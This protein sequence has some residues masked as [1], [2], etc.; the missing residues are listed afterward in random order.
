VSS[1]IWFAL[2]IGNS[3]LHWARF[4]AGTLQQSWDTPHLSVE[5]VR[6]ILADRMDLSQLQRC[7]RTDRVAPDSNLPELW[8][9][10]V[11][12]EQASLWCNY[13]AAQ[14]ITLDRVPL[15][16]MYSSL[17]ID[18]AVAVWGA[19][20]TVGAPVLVIDSGTALTF[21]AA[22]A[23]QFLIG[24]AILPGLRLQ[25]QALGQG[26]AALPLLPGFDPS[27]A[28]P[29]RWATTTADAIASGILYTILAGLRD[30][31]E[32]WWQEFPHGQVV[33]T[34]GDCDRLYACLL[35]QC[36][37]LAARMTVDPNLVFWGL[38][39]LKFGS[40]SDNYWVKRKK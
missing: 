34:G 1:S 19:I 5:A 18:R 25:F 13:G 17:G 24:G 3:R 30:F 27:D 7:D 11:V 39:S 20:A 28:L 32:Q 21:T 8:I 14:I 26:T 12:P 16:G 22:N 10:S 6:Q 15:Q 23:D 35:D 4:A 9:A 29:P 40:A 31:T 36:P 37:A 2:A 38:R 33:L